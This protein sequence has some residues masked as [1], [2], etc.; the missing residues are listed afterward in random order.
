MA[1][2]KI[3][4]AIRDYVAGK[5]GVKQPSKGEK[6]AAKKKKYAAYLKDRKARND[7]DE[8]RQVRL[9]AYKEAERKKS[10]ERARKLRAE[11]EALGKP[12]WK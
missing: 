7:A 12:K 8:A 9:R 2:A 4:G 1:G 3:E 5:R 10:N 11:W 6:A